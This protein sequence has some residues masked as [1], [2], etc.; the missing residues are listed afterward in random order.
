V[1]VAAATLVRSASG[2]T[3]SGLFDPIELCI[4]Q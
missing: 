3:T 2:K 1:A 4:I